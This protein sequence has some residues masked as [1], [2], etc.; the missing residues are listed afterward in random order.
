MRS[1]TRAGFSPDGAATGWVHAPGIPGVSD[2]TRVP[3]PADSQRVRHRGSRATVRRELV[4]GGHP[5]VPRAPGCSLRALHD[6]CRRSSR[7]RD[8]RR[9]RGHVSSATRFRSRRRR[10][11]RS[12]TGRPDPIASFG[13]DSSPRCGSWNGSGRTR[14]RTK[15]RAARLASTPRRTSARSS[16]LERRSRRPSTREADTRSSGFRAGRS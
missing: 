13:R 5:P 14:S 6:R 8:A 7:L 1:A 4:A 15:K 16:A 9:S 2:R 10:S 11:S 12:S 3:E